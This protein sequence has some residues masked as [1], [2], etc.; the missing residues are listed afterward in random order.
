MNT[1]S[2]LEV[3]A[4]IAMR[5]YGKYRDR[6]QNQCLGS[7]GIRKDGAV[8]HSHNTSAAGCVNPK[9]HAEYRLLTRL[10]PFGTIYVARVAGVGGSTWAMA[11]PCDHCQAAMA[12]RWVKRVFYTIGP[13]EYGSLIF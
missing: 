12:S 13:G 1:V 10:G 9:T 6:R 4:G 3:A 11:R 8:V 7:I 5:S 2:A